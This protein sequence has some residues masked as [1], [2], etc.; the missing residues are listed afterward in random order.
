MAELTK[1]GRYD[2]MTDTV[3]QLTGE[4]AT[5]M[6]DFVKLHAADFAHSP[7]AATAS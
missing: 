3:R 2:R 6:R 1:E 4:T 5:G 7:A